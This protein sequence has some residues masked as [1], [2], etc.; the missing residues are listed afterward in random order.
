MPPMLRRAGVAWPSR[1]SSALTDVSDRLP[2]SRNSPGQGPSQ[3]PATQTLPLHNREEST[4][5]GGARPPVPHPGG[6]RDYHREKQP[7]PRP[8]QAKHVERGL[9]KIWRRM[10]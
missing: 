10:V 2:G 9:T 4:P 6:P 7:T 8:K 1:H 5:H 3:P